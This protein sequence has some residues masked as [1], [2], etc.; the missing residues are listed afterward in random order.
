MR[1]TIVAK[2]W[3]WGLFLLLW[4]AAPATTDAQQLVLYG[5]SSGSS[6]SI[7]SLSPN[8]PKL[9][10][11]DPATVAAT[12][13]ANLTVGLG[14]MAFDPATGVLYGVTAPGFQP[15]SGTIRQ[16]VRVNTATGEETL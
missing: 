7:I 16:L 11:I 8:G 15:P 14:A 9:Y 12:V 10:I 3:R 5:A 13:Q 6:A 4:L 2:S 1:V